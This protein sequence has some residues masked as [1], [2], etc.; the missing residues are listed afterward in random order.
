MPEASAGS[1]SRQS[2]AKPT[3]FQPGDQLNVEYLQLTPSYYRAIKIA[4][5]KPGTPGDRTRVTAGGCFDRGGS[6]Q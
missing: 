1:V 4:L 3:D 2:T 6:R 5:I